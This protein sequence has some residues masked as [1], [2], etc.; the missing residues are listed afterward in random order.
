[1][2]PITRGTEVLGNIYLMLQK[3]YS[4]GFV[5]FAFPFGYVTKLSISGILTYSAFCERSSLGDVLYCSM[6]HYMPFIL[7]GHYWLNSLLR[8]QKKKEK[9][10]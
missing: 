6:L 1:M 7:I 10:E 5:Y 2:T 9:R 3:S 8:R 4:V